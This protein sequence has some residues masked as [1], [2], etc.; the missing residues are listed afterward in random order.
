MNIA[1]KVKEINPTIYS[2]MIEKGFNFDAGRFPEKDP[3]G[4]HG[5]K[6]ARF[7]EIKNYIGNTYGH[8]LIIGYD[9]DNFMLDVISQR[10]N[11]RGYTPEELKES[12]LKKPSQRLMGL[13]DC[14]SLTYVNMQTLREGKLISCGCKQRE[15]VA[16]SNKNRSKRIIPK[17]RLWNI[18]HGMIERCYNPKSNRYYLYGAKGVRICY[19]WYCPDFNAPYGEKFLKGFTNFASWAYKYGGFY[20]QDLKTTPGSEI[21][22]IERSDVEGDYCPE[23]CTFIPKGK[24]ALNRSTT[25]YY[26]MSDVINEQESLMSTYELIEKYRPQLIRLAKSTGQNVS[27]VANTVYTRIHKGWTP[28]DAVTIPS[29]ATRAALDCDMIPRDIDPKMIGEYYDGPRYT[30]GG[31]LRDKDGFLVLDMSVKFAKMMKEK[32]A[33]RKNK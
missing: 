28:F 29:R 9:P 33:A 8:I 16:G 6:D 1:A 10:K 13:C 7:K 11:Y 3:H 15:V 17:S 31:E 23:N 27:K 26:D 4:Y 21:L 32:E 22:T 2:T 24:Q 20:E 12:Y 14:G 19:D 25:N 5:S 30:E 18:Y